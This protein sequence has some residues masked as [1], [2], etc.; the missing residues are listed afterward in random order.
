MDKDYYVFNEDED[1]GEGERISEKGLIWSVMVS[2][3][4]YLFFFS[5]GRMMCGLKEKGESV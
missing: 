4:F 3:F 5:S 2:G 1:E